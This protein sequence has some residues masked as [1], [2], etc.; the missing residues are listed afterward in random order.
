[1]TFVGLSSMVEDYRRRAELCPWC[2]DREWYEEAETITEAI[3][4]AALGRTAKWFHSRNHNEGCRRAQAEGRHAHQHRLCDNDLIKFH[5][6]LLDCPGIID[7]PGDFKSLYAMVKRSSNAGVGELAIYDT[8]LRLGFYWRR[9]PTEVYL[10]MGTRKGA[11]RMARF[12]AD[13]A[14]AKACRHA[15]LKLELL[16]VSLQTLEAWEAEDFLCIF[17]HRFQVHDS[18][19]G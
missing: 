18:E 5:A 1:M 9:L 16:P 12:L 13:E 6:T 19:L 7:D 2:H 4:R 8:A 15:T 14:L 10:H 3:R 11:K 17:K